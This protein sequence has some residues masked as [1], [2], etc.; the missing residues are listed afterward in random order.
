M[1]SWHLLQ[2]VLASMFVFL[3]QP[4]RIEIPVQLSERHI[5]SIRGQIHSKS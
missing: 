1:D 3:R 2:L 4:D 5:T